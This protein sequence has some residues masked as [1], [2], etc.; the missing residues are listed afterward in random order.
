MPKSNP[1]YSGTG[2][3]LH[4][5]YFRPCGH[6]PI[7]T[8]SERLV[9]NVIKGGGGLLFGIPLKIGGRRFA[10]FLSTTY[11]W[12]SVKQRHFIGGSKKEMQA[13]FKECQ[14]LKGVGS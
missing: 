4:T 11:L 1:H 2:I 9:H 13:D 8:E 12:K 3:N 10:G 14:A 7:H 5:S 6:G